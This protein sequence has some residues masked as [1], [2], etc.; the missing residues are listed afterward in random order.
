L[1]IDEGAVTLGGFVDG[2]ADA[3]VIAELV[4]NVPGVVAVDATALTW[5]H[6]DELRSSPQSH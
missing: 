1:S 5:R 2:E 6:A 4:R 3:D